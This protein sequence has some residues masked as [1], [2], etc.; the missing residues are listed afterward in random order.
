MRTTFSRANPF[1]WLLFLAATL[2]L[3]ICAGT[4]A[5]S[6][7]PT[8][9]VIQITF[10]PVAELKPACSPDGRWLAFEYFPR[11]GLTGPEIWIMPI[12]G[13][14]KLARPLVKDGLYYAGISWSPDSEWIS[15]TAAMPDKQEANKGGLLTSQIFKVNIR[16]GQVVQLTSLAKNTVV[17][18]STSWSIRGEI[19]F[20]MDDDIYA[21]RDS[22]G[23]AYKLVDFHAIQKMPH[24]PQDIAWS[25]DGK[26]IAFEANDSLDS[27]Q[28]ESGSLWVVEVATKTANAIL[29]RK[30]IGGASW[31]DANRLVLAL[32]NDD[33]LSTVFLLSLDTRHLEKLTS[34][35]FDIWPCYAEQR[36]TLFFNHNRSLNP[37]FE[38]SIVPSLHI[39]HK[40]LRRSLQK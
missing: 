37:R 26:Q 34:G 31:V 9:S 10:G 28:R 33:H 7:E 15:Y 1:L 22:G 13:G 6:R 36:K 32:V 20:S 24:A 21:V 27:E 8:P 3:T 40:H 30:Q 38:G 35:P 5:I 23:G 4:L 39:W 25:P 17:E 18:D 16:S 2:H 12:D 29:T 11:S 19:A 14:F